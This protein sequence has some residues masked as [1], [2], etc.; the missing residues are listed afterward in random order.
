MNKNNFEIN[1]LLRRLDMFGVSYNFQVNGKE[2]FKTTS[3]AIVTILYTLILTGLFFGFG[4]DLYQREDLRYLLT[5][6]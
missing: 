6:I 4:V 5:R 1:R 2:R 3:G